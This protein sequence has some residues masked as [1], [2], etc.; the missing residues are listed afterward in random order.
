MDKVTTDASSSQNNSHY[1]IKSMNAKMVDDQNRMQPKYCE[2]GPADG[3]MRGEK[4][5]T[6]KGP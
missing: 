4:R 2:P 5:N 1:Q 3:V 6:Q